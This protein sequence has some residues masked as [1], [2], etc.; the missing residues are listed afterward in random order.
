MLAT[1]N[2]RIILARMIRQT[3][4]SILMASEGNAGIIFTGD[5]NCM[6]GSPEMSVL[7]APDNGLQVY[8]N[9][10]ENLFRNGRGTYRYQGIWEMPDQVIVSHTLLNG[11]SGIKTGENLLKILYMP[12]LLVKDPAYPGYRP[13]STYTGYRYQGGFSD[14]LPVILDIIFQ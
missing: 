3:G 12:S 14:H 4:D 9:L 10:S 7:L 2:L 13:Y 8:F 11:S 6:P 1:E 5:F